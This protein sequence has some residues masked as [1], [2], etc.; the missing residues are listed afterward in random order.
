MSMH[1]LIGA[2]SEEGHQWVD[3]LCQV[4]SGNVDYACDYIASHFKGI[5]LSRPQGT[6]MLYL[7]CLV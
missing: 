3:E 7:D 1:A 5:S 6:Y 4:L 2:Y